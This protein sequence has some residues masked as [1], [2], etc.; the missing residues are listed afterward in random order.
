MLS[1]FLY[2]REVFSPTTEMSKLLQDLR[3]DIKK[4][5]DSDGTIS[6]DE[7]R[8]LLDGYL[9]SLKSLV[10]GRFY[11][12]LSSS[13]NPLELA[14]KIS[15]DVGF[16][17]C[18]SNEILFY[19]RQL[20]SEMIDSYACV[21][22][23]IEKSEPFESLWVGLERLIKDHQ[24]FVK[25]IDYKSKFFQ[26]EFN[27]LNLLQ[28]IVT[29]FLDPYFVKIKNL[30]VYKLHNN[31]MKIVLNLDNKFIK[32]Y[33]NLKK[34]KETYQENYNKWQEE[35]KILLNFDVKFCNDVSDE[36]ESID[37]QI[38][39]YS[40]FSKLLCSTIKE[41]NVDDVDT[42][43]PVIKQMFVCADAARDNHIVDSP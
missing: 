36:F 7:A 6:R 13:Q 39:I 10:Y 42:I 22:K 11:H 26:S 41:D 31:N 5:Q 2:E 4:S 15:R 34:L 23:I 24:R 35:E 29:P 1:K 16:P 18:S 30:Y 19:M 12:V 32:K 3:E 17:S 38:T 40:K 27:I 28:G 33:Q 9:F 25:D 37:Q 20:A 8:V 14:K 43:L 21:H